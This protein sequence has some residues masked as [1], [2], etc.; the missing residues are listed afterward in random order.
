MLVEKGKLNVYLGSNGIT[1]LAEKCEFRHALILKGNLNR[2]TH[3]VAYGL[4]RRVYPG[5][6]A[7]ELTEAE[8]K[9]VEFD[10]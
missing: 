6:E 10:P 2:P 9:G 8:E 1:L 4:H 7:S 3:R 5:S